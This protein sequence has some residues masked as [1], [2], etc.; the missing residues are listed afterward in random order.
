[1]SACYRRLATIPG[2]VQC[3][4]G[5]TYG[6]ILAGQRHDQLI[7]ATFTAH[8]RR[9]GTWNDD[10]LTAQQ[11]LPSVIPQG[12]VLAAAAWWASRL[13]NCHHDVVGLSA[14]NRQLTAAGM[15]LAISMNLEAVRGK[16]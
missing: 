12:A 16:Y 1:M 11:A 3:V 10:G 9:L 8:S 7:M 14:P 4:A 13:G 2:R 5:I 6:P 15:D